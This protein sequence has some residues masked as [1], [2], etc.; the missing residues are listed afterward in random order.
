MIPSRLE[1]EY[2]RAEGLAELRKHLKLEVAL[3]RPLN[4][5]DLE[6]TMALET[7]IH[8]FRTQFDVPGVRYW[9]YRPEARMP[10]FFTTMTGESIPA[11]Y[12]AGECVELLRHEFLGRQRIFNY[13]D[14]SL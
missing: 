2:H 4:K 10:L 12:P 11:K 6:M 8:E 7:I 9:E 13:E 14:D 5:I 1:T 3:G